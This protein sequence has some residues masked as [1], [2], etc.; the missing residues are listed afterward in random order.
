[1][2]R[3]RPQ[4]IPRAWPVTRRTMWGIWVEETTTMRSP[5]IQA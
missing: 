4:G 3:T 5:S 2:T 1:M